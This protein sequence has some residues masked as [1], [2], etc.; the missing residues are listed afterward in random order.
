MNNVKDEKNED[1]DE[2]YDEEERE[3]GGQSGFSLL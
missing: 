3:D 1:V 2:K